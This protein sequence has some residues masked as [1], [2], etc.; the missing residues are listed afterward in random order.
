MTMRGVTKL[1]V[2][3]RL[4]AINFVAGTIAL[5]AALVPGHAAADAIKIGI[6]KVPASGAI[7]IAQEKG[8][9]AAEGIPAELVFFDAGLPIA[10]GVTSGGLDFG[11]T[12]ATA[13]FYS[14][15]GQGAL[16][17]IAAQ[18]E[19]VAHFQGQAFFA[20]NRAYDMGLRSPKAIKGHIFATTE[21]GS[22]GHY[23][24]GLVAAK[25]GFD[26]ATIR[27]MP[28]GSIANAVSAVAGGQADFTLNAVTAEKAA[29]ERGAGKIVGFIGDEA[30]FQ[31]A[32][33]FSSTQ[34]ANERRDT[35]ERF[36]RANRK[37]ARDFHDAFTGPDGKRR[38]GPT[39]PEI[40]GI[41]AK[42][43]GQSVEQVELGVTYIDADARLDVKDVLRQID[44]YKSQDL[45][46]GQV[47]GD[48]IIDKRYVIALP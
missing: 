5:A 40:L 13:A 36:L 29:V 42:Y 26:L 17:I 2:S 34:M 19:E 10:L 6:V 18:T 30:P 3:S 48:E 24:V 32:L 41:I 1:A 28:F 14:L 20:S 47:N 16:K 44:W 11:A 4:A 38:D 37:A 15:A 46:K 9:F 21:V 22:P 25:Y 39:A 7:F 23:G 45:V 8:Y 33:A 35:V 27:I 43:T 31:F 12:A